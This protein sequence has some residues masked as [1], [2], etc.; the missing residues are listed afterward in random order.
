MKLF[1]LWLLYTIFTPNVIVFLLAI[2]GPG[3]YNEMMQSFYDGPTVICYPI[4]AVIYGIM[5]YMKTV[6]DGNKVY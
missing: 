3:S 5:L 1:I 6:P 2:I 4:L